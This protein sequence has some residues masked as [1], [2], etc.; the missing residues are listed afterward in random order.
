MLYILALLFTVMA[1]N[2]LPFRRRKKAIL[3][4]VRDAPLLGILNFSLPQEG[5][6]IAHNVITEVHHD[7]NGYAFYPYSATDTAMLYRLSLTWLLLYASIWLLCSMLIF[8]NTR[9]YSALFMLSPLPVFFT[10]PY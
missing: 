10:L 7:A 2:R 6:H 3:I 9:H 1:Y 4:L 5:A 8:W